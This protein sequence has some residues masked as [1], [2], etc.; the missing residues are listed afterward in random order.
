MSSNL[1]LSHYHSHTISLKY[2]QGRSFIYPELYVVQPVICELQRV[3][4]HNTIKWF[5]LYVGLAQA[6]IVTVSWGVYDSGLY[7][8][9]PW[10]RH[11]WAQTHITGFWNTASYQSKSGIILSSWWL[12]K[13]SEM[14]VNIIVAELTQTHN[15]GFLNTG[16]CK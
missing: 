11:S 2:C 12:E 4:T 1:A 9:Y 10:S 5:F 6:Q 13:N 16:Y 14:N 7:N 8:E 3:R 15:I